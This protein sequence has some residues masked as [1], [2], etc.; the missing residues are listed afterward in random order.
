MPFG[1]F[2][3]VE[4]ADL[5][6]DY[7]DW[8]VSI[9]LRD[10]LLSAVEAERKL[11]SSPPAPSVAPEVHTAALEV[12]SAGLRTLARAHH[13]DLGGETAVMQS[14]NIAVGWLRQLVR[15]AS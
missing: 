3:G 8:L 4:V 11:R 5:P 12:I 10:P 1:K 15:S 14:I 6:D 2:K 9:D 13:P 7:L